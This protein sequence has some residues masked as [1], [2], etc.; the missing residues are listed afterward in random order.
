M[1][2]LL[3]PRHSERFLALMTEHYPAWPI[4]RAELNDLPLAA[5][6]WGESKDRGHG[7]ARQL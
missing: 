6:T 2:H 7:Q 3:E 5:A 1:V 4:A